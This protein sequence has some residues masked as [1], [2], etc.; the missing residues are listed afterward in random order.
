M[1]PLVSTGVVEGSAAG[2]QVVVG[3]ILEAGVE[4]TLALGAEVEGGIVAL[5]AGVEGGTVALGTGVEGGTVALVVVVVEMTFLVA[6]E[7]GEEVLA[8]SVAGVGMTEHLMT[9][10]T[11]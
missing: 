1:V 10:M 9:G 8:G 2:I 4:G 7:T 6:V 3:G 5:G 11:I